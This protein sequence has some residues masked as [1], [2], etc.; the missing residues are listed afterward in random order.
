MDDDRQFMIP[1][2]VEVRTNVLQKMS[3]PMEAHYGEKWAKYYNETVKLTK[4]I[5]GTNNET[6][7]HV[8]SG[9]AGLESVI[10]S[11]SSNED[12]ILVLN[13]GFW[14]QR[15]KEIIEINNGDFEE[16][17]YG[18]DE[19]I[20]L[21]E[22]EEK[23]KENPSKFNLIAMVHTE[24]STGFKNQIKEVAEIADKYG[25]ITMVDAVCSIGVDRYKMDAWN[26]DI[27]VTASQKGLGAPPG[28]TIISI[29]DK[30]WN[31]MEHNQDNISGWYL[32]LLNKKRF[33]EKKRDWQ[34]Y[35]ITMAV[36][37]LKALK[38]ALNNIKDEGLE[39]RIKR[40]EKIADMFRRAVTSMG[41]D[42]WAGNSEASNGLTTIKIPGKTKSGRIVDIFEDDYNI[43]IG[44]G[45][46]KLEG[47][48]VRIGHMNVGASYNSIT[49]VISALKDVKTQIGM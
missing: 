10:N 18:W 15:I 30:A 20:D 33:A 26:I 9:H 25:L 4:D 6:F 23:I 8:G 28:L 21:E 45:L 7:I 24:T 29:S 47:D 12:K 36:N 13:N 22:V 32:N 17:T 41:Y 39:N 19:T 46:G 11:F 49:P 2:P 31:Y 43:I 5:I 16:I 3:S 35:S 14:A 1:G 27:T 34:P 40:H 42:L 48:I 38:Q 44:N 37:N